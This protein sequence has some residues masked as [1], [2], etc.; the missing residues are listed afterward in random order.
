M[1]ETAA[2]LLI[3]KVLTRMGAATRAV[4]GEIAWRSSV[5]GKTWVVDLD[6]PGGAWRPAPA[7]GVHD[8]LVAGT[9]GGFAALLAG[10]QA[11]RKSLLNG[12]LTVTGNHSR[13]GKLAQQLAR[14]GSP[15]AQR[16]RQTAAHKSDRVPTKVS[17]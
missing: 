16:L 14:G 2:L 5:S 13:L 6:A 11:M 9:D 17:P 15:F 8:L 10:G 7:D 12:E 1:L 4:G 3:A